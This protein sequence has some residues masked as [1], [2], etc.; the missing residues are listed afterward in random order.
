MTQTSTRPLQSRPRTWYRDG[1]IITQDVSRTDFE[2]LTADLSP[3]TKKKS[4]VGPKTQYLVLF[5]P[6]PLEDESN[7]CIG[8]ICFEPDTSTRKAAVTDLVLRRSWRNQGL[9]DWMVQCAKE[10][11]KGWTMTELVKPGG[12][13]RSNLEE[14]F[15]RS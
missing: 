6:T 8:Y 13:P 10:C 14:K 7:S 15:C 1:Y 5:T 12:A 3:S 4:T 2:A 11:S 9:E